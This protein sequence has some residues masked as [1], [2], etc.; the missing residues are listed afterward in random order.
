VTIREAITENVYD[1]FM[2]LT[3]LAVEAAVPTATSWGAPR[4]QGGLVW[5]TYKATTRRNGVYAGA[6]G[7]RNFNEQLWE[8]IDKRLV[9]GWERAFHRCLPNA[10]SQF[11]REAKKH[12]EAVHRFVISEAEAAGAFASVNMLNQLVSA[13][14]QL[15]ADM[16]TI[17]HEIAQGVQVQA[18]RGFTPVVQDQMTLAYDI[19]TAERG[20]S[21][22]SDS[23]FIHLPRE[24]V[25]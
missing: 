19:C 23:A 12:I 6:S 4:M 10:T 1:N 24:Q 21:C 2:R 11:A 5:A 25:T 16:P 15:V 8:P 13:N 7:P 17:V 18:N 3:P 22:E 9:S 20:R 14:L